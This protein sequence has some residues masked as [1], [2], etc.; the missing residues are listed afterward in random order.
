MIKYK[1]TTSILSIC[2]IALDILSLIKFPYQGDCLSW[3]LDKQMKAK[4]QFAF[5]QFQK[6]K[7][8]L[9]QLEALTLEEVGPAEYQAIQVN[10]FR[11]RN[12]IQEAEAYLIE[13][14]VDNAFAVLRFNSLI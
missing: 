2:A 14:K 4:K 6:V 9:S 1:L 10:C 3:V 7:E 13:G 12:T 8:E 5:T 11:M